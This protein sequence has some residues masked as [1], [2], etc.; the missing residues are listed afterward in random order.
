MTKPG[1]DQTA[2]IQR[3]LFLNRTTETVTV[4][5]LVWFISNCAMEM[6]SFLGPKLK[7]IFLKGHMLLCLYVISL[8]SQHSHGNGNIGCQV[9]IDDT[10]FGRLLVGSLF[11][12]SLTYNRSTSHLV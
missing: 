7:C 9:L 5:Q 1:S 11:C 3:R 4:R 6:N 2:G 8:G 10:N 12:N